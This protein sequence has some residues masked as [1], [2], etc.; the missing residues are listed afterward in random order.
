MKKLPN[1][2]FGQP[3]TCCT[4]FSE[5]AHVE[6]SPEGYDRLGAACLVRACVEYSISYGRYSGYTGIVEKKMQTTIVF[7]PKI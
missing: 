2:V 6:F 4:R 5:N 1:R 7:Y 3:H